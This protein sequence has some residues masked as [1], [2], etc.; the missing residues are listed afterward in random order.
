[1]S[2]REE[3]LRDLAER[4]AECNG[5]VRLVST[6]MATAAAAAMELAQGFPESAPIQIQQPPERPAT[7]PV[8]FIVRTEP[9]SFLVTP[10]ASDEA[11]AYT[12]TVAQAEHVAEALN[13]LA[14]VKEAHHALAQG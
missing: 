10:A 9:G 6:V 13:M 1:M 8:R 4:L 2:E 11:I 3:A 12:Q 7:V 14:A 5:A